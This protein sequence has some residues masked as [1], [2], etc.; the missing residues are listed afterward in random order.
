MKSMLSEAEIE[1]EAMR[2]HQAE[3]E[4][5]QVEATSMLYPG[6]DIDDA[7]AIQQAGIRIKLALGQRVIGHKIGLTSRAMQQQMRIDEPDY[8]TLLDSM[9]FKNGSRIPAKEHLDPRLEVEL[10][11][12]LK[13][14]L[15][16]EDLSIEDVIAAT[17]CVLPCFELIAARSYRV[18][19]ATGIPRNV[20]DT[21]S[22]NAANAGIIM[23]D[24]GSD[25]AGI[26]LR[27]AGAICFR[28]DIVEETGLAAG[29]LNHPAEGIRWLAR[30]LAPHGVSLEPGHLILSGSFI[31][32]IPAR[33]GDTF[34]ADFGAL[35]SVSCDFI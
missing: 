10:A 30:R 29:V 21:I 4:R 13:E 17:E 24:K 19:P 31:R 7:Y 3:V 16:G 12:L 14:P 28:N 8:G 1:K 27:W 34:L 32:P 15:Q 33:P 25:P 22:D 9:H 2:L 35:G 20:L 5:R 23:A 26:D 11:F 6:M 18:N